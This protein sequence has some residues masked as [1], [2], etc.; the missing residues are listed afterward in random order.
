MVSTEVNQIELLPSHGWNGTQDAMIQQ[1]HN[2][3]E[4]KEEYLGS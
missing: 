1:Q 2:G 4:E 3:D